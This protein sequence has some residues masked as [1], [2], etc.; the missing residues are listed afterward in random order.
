MS[1]SSRPVLKAAAKRVARS[2]S[3]RKSILRSNKRL[4][5]EAAYSE[6]S[7]DSELAEEYNWRDQYSSRKQYNDAQKWNA[8]FQEL[9]LFKAKHGHCNVPRKAGKLGTWV[10]H[11]RKQYRMLQEGKHSCICDERIQKL[12]SIGFQ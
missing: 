8:R 6:A 12:E 9:K 5:Q 10:K 7:V 3:K 1:P 11:Q 4:G 2:R